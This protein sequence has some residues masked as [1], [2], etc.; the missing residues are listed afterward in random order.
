[1]SP[2]VRESKTVL[3]SRFH[4]VDFGFQ[5]LDFSLSGTWIWIPIVSVISDS[6]SCMADFK[7]R[8]PDSKSKIPEIP[9]FREGVAG[10]LSWGGGGLSRGV[11][12]EG[13]ISLTFLKQIM[14]Y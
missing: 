9:D 2:Q 11:G 10:R 7:L 4:A 5:V 6:L 3:D 14:T 13:V 1:M 12:G 8:S